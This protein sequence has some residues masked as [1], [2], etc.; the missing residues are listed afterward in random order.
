MLSS[1]NVERLR[2]WLVTGL[3]SLQPLISMRKPIHHQ[4][5]K[6]NECLKLKQIKVK[7][8]SFNATEYL[9]F[10]FTLGVG[11]LLNQ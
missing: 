10:Y 1:S 2:N 8:N 3:F 5:I 9:L 7:L 11:C 6:E 4:R